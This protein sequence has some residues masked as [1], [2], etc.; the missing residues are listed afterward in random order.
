MVVKKRKNIP[1][2][3]PSK[4]SDKI[5]GAYYEKYDPVDLIDAGYFE[6]DGI[7][8]GDKRVVDLRTERGM[9]TIPIEAPVARK[10]YRVARRN[11]CTPSHL[12]TLL[13]PRHNNDVQIGC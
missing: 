9:V 13:E 3:P 4:D 10:L 11:G 12:A 8:E 7:F 5:K 2:L 6:E 1:P